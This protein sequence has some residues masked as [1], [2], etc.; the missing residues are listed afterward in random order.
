M[1]FRPLALALVCSLALIGAACG[2]NDEDASSRVV[3]QQQFAAA[4][5]TKAAPSQ[6]DPASQAQLRQELR[7]LWEQHV[8]W[9]RLYIVSAL[10]DLPD[11]QA[12]AD[13]LL[14][15]Q[16]DIG[17]AIKP[18]YGEAAGAKL[19]QLLRTHITEAADLLKAAKAGDQPH[20][21][22]AKDAWYANGDDIAN[23]LSQ[24]NPDNWPADQVKMMIRMHLDQ[25]IAEATHRLQNN[26][27]AEIADYDAIEDHMLKLADTLATGIA[28]QFPDKVAGSATTSDLPRTD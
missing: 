10:S 15:N 14:R 22:K 11:A 5:Q 21:T 24:A 7:K 13:R 8:A 9:T 26:H 12:T 6:A 18:F 1:R 27:V 16:D 17:A 3:H 2:T 28:A 20:L 19:T 4:L 25:T 23:F